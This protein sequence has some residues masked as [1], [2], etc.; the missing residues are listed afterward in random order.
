MGS[1]PGSMI[2]SNDFIEKSN[3][4]ITIFDIKNYLL[5]ISFFKFKQ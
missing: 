2:L 4:K 1:N 5:F 3:P